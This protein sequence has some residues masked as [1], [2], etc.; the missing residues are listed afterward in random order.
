MDEAQPGRVLGVLDW[1][2]STLG[3]PLADLAYLCM[4]YHMP[5]VRRRWSSRTF[6]SQALPTPESVCASFAKPLR[7]PFRL[8][9]GEVGMAFACQWPTQPVKTALLT[10]S[11]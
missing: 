7:Q 3:D 4:P 5:Q 11:R 1:E 6:P 8:T 10:L 2:L 9:T